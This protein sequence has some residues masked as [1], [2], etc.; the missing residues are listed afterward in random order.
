MESKSHEQQAQ[1]VTLALK[2]VECRM[3]KLGQ[4]TLW[5]APAYTNSTFWDDA[6]ILTKRANQ[7][8]S[9]TAATSEIGTNLIEK[10][11]NNIV[12]T[13]DEIINEANHRK[14]ETAICC[15]FHGS[16]NEFQIL[17]QKFQGNTLIMFSDSFLLCDN[18][19]NEVLSGEY[20]DWICVENEL[21]QRGGFY[22]RVFG[23]LDNFQLKGM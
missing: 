3:S 18:M 14:I 19:N 6:Y 1:L 16:E 7:F 20:P 22:M 11:N 13:I 21:M 12:G 2:Y 15:S 23:K 10:H 8:A 5:I 9:F 4:T 17:L